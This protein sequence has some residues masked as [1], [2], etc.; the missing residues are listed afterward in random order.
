MLK[1]SQVNYIMDLS[2]SGYRVAEISKKLKLDRKTVWKYLS[3]EDFSPTP[4]VPSKLAPYKP[5]ILEWLAEDQQDRRSRKKQLRTL[6][7]LTSRYGLETALEAMERSIH[8][9]HL[10]SCDAAVLAA[11]SSSRR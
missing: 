10:S 11:T 6:A 7:E 4:P 2:N 9:G 8:G 5:K 3:Q 1:T